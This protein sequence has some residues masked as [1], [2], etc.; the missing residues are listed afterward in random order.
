MSISQISKALKVQRYK[1]TQTIYIDELWGNVDLVQ[2]LP[3]PALV[4]QVR[5]VSCSANTVD[6]DNL[7]R[8]RNDIEARVWLSL[9]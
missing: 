2:A 3:Q 4:A 5:S 6:R 8:A 1:F 7:V 9:L